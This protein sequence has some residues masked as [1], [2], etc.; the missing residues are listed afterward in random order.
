MA[1]L[2]GFVFFVAG[3]TS[4]NFNLVVKESYKQMCIHDKLE[5]NKIKDILALEV[6]K[7][8]CTSYCPCW[9]G[10]PDNLNEPATGVVNS[11]SP[12]NSTFRNFAMFTGYMGASE[13]ELN[14]FGRTRMPESVGSFV[15]SDYKFKSDGKTQ[16]SFSS[17]QECLE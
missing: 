2:I 1:A 11:T 5:T 14:D 13:K 7:H 6:N 12:I 3:M 8:M 16:I 17:F 10:H 9:S 15:W 4:L